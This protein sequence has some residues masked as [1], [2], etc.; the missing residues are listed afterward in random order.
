[1]TTLKLTGR[2]LA[3]GEDT[4]RYRLLTYGEEGNTS[5]GRVTIDAGALTVPDDVTAL[6][7]VNIEH[8]RLRPVGRVVAL[9]NTDQH[10]DVEVRTLETTAGR[11]V[12]LEA[13]EGVRAGISVEI[14]RVVI[15][16][17]RLVAGLLAG[18]GLVVRPAFPSSMLTASDVGTLDTDEDDDQEDEDQHDDEADADEDEQDDDAATEQDTST[19][20]ADQAEDT[21]TT[22]PSEEDTM[23]NTT[24]KA[25]G[26][27]GAHITARD[28]EQPA[29]FG[30]EQLTA[31]LDNME[32]LRSEGRLTAALSPINQTSIYDKTAVPEY[33]G[34]LWEGRSPVERYAGLVKD[35]GPLTAAVSKGWAFT[36]G[37]EVHPYAGDL[38][39]IT[40]TPVTVETKEIKAERLAGGN[41][42]DRIYSDLPDAGFWDSYL[43]HSAQDYAVKR[44]ARIGYHIMSNA[45]AA[46]YDD[47]TT[48]TFYNG[49]KGWAY[50]IRAARLA[51]NKII[52][53][54]AIVGADLW[55]EMALTP[56]EY[57]LEYLSA[58]LGLDDTGSLEGFRIIGAASD[59]ITGPDGTSTFDMAGKVLVGTDQTT[60]KQELP[61]GP[62]RVNAEVINNAGVDHGVFGYI[63]LWTPTKYNYVVAAKPAV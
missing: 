63:K 33:V 41:R 6:E 43:R 25:A 46:E 24:V 12:Q 13:R 14:D 8:D 52:P 40:S 62:I 36:R 35:N 57:A 38:A 30:L 7:A 3:A 60:L 49:S 37:P 20:D 34:E 55:E 31:A 23:G 53:N 19:T 56:R 16:A 26:I 5:A 18:A 47:A 28:E 2:L 42:L 4:L 21:S 54:F 50:L 48:P 51:M 44:D 59:P 29:P 45:T 17:G 27:P 32:D 15:R 58:Q 22:E 11:D 1:M 39:A 61:G 9:D 10:L